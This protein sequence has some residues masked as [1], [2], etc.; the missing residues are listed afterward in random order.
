M[1]IAIEPATEVSILDPGVE[2]VAFTFVLTTA[3]GIRRDYHYL[4]T[5]VG[6]W[7]PR[8]LTDLDW[9]KHW[10]FSFGDDALNILGFRIGIKWGTH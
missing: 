9:W 7:I 8:Y 10:A 3:L 4:V 6:W 2:L 5:A 1:Q